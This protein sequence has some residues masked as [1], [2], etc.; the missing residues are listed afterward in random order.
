M[1]DLLGGNRSKSNAFKE[2][3]GRNAGLGK[4]VTEAARKRFSLDAPIK[5]RGHTPPLK[6]AMHVQMVKVA[7]RLECNETDNLGIN[8]RHKTD[9]LAELPA[10]TF[11]VRRVGSPCRNLLRRVVLCGDGANRFGEE[12]GEGGNVFRPVK[13]D[14][15]DAPA[16]PSLPFR[17]ADFCVLH[18]G[19]LLV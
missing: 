15:H 7:V 10:P 6:A 11:H 18:D 5:C 8:F 14:V 13:T 4:D 16:M 12:A 9:T 19:V 17:S 1:F 2:W 3:A